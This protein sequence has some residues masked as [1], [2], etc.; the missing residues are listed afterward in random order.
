LGLGGGGV[1]FVFKDAGLVADAEQQRAAGA[2]WGD[3]LEGVLAEGGGGRDGDAQPEAGGFGGEDCSGGAG[4]VEEDGLGAVEVFAED[5][6][7]KGRARP[8]AHRVDGGRD[9]EAVLNRIGAHRQTKRE[10]A[11]EKSLHF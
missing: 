6:G 2:A 8:G 7:F 4:L 1:G 9:G 3:D 11:K 10:R 5:L